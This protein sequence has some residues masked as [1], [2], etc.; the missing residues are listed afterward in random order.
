MQ[1]QHDL[2][3]CF[4]STASVSEKSSRF[5]LRCRGI[6]DWIS[7][8]F[9]PHFF[10][11]VR[12][13]IF[14]NFCLYHNVWINILDKIYLHFKLKEIIMHEYLPTVEESFSCTYRAKLL[15]HIHFFLSFLLSWYGT[16]AQREKEREKGSCEKVLRSKFHERRRTW[17]IVCLSG[18]YFHTALSLLST[19]FHPACM[20]IFQLVCLGYL[21]LLVHLLF[22]FYFF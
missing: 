7:S 14:G 10:S 12:K 11:D 1:G 5:L 2:F 4:L 15:I 3:I 21:S 8:W 6:D 22:V 17:F 19:D 9:S 20:S 13:K 16:T 18:P